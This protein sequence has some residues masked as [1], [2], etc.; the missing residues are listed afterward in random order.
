M[1]YLKSYRVFESEDKCFGERDVTNLHFEEGQWVRWSD[2]PDSYVEIEEKLGIDYNDLGFILMDFVEKYDLLYSCDY[3][4]RTSDTVRITVKFYPNSMT[5]D[6]RDYKEWI[7]DHTIGK[8]GFYYQNYEPQ[9]WNW[10][11]DIID[12]MESRLNEH[13]LTTDKEIFINTSVIEINITKL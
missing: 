10:D 1:R 3:S 5:P 7:Y 6:I 12:E 13:G 9:T 2:D 11:Q 4:P 8:S